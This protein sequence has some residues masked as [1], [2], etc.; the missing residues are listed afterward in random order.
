MSEL[1]TEFMTRDFYLFFAILF[2]IALVVYLVV[3]LRHAPIYGLV[4]NGVP[5][6]IRVLVARTFAARST[7]LLNHLSLPSNEGLVFERVHKLHTFG[8]KFEIDIV[9]VSKRGEVIQVASRIGPKKK[10]RAPGGTHYAVELCGGRSEELALKVGDLVKLEKIKP[11]KTR[12]LGK[13][14]AI[15]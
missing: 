1:F 4:I 7:G 11:A 8:M 6:G 12:S 15:P 2:L 9:F 13:T 3:P 14:P 10:I 5:A